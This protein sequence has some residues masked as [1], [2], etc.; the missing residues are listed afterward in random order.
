MRATGVVHRRQ[1]GKVGAAITP[2]GVAKIW[3]K[4]CTLQEKN[5][6]LNRQNSVIKFNGNSRNFGKKLGIK[7]IVKVGNLLFA[8]PIRD[9]F[10]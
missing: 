7:V 3:T 2:S 6:V 10:V 4:F 8:Y 1:T 9:K 5:A